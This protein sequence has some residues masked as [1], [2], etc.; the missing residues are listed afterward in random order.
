ML[1]DARRPVVLTRERVAA[2]LTAP[3]R[4]G[5]RSTRTR[6]PSAAGS[7]EAAAASS[8]GRGPGDLAY[9]IYTSGSTGRPKAVAI[10]H[11]SAVALAF[12]AREVFPLEDL[13]G[14]LSRDLAL[15][16]PLRV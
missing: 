10:E 13:A 12:W 1:E 9:V 7:G 6:T 14:V 3:R 5:A 11:R 4:E 16:R 8:A 15:L 2:S